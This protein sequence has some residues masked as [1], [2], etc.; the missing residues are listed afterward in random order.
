MCGF[1]AIIGAGFA[2]AFFSK[3]RK[4]NRNKRLYSETGDSYNNGSTYQPDPFAQNA[5]P[6]PALAASA[7][8]AADNI[9]GHNNQWDHQQNYNYG[10]IAP[11]TPMTSVAKQH[12]PYYST[13]PTQMGYAN[14][15]NMN[16]YY[17]N[18]YQQQYY[19]PNAAYYEQQHYDQNYVDSQKQ[20]YDA[21]AAPQHQSP[22]LNHNATNLAPNHAPTTA[23]SNVYSSPHSYPD[24][25]VQQAA[26]GNNPSYR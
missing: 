10:N 18:N 20:Q 22:V 5:R 15:P 26:N 19:D 2:Y 17:N 8:V 3:T 23:A 13:G 1:I 24:E 12:D 6:S 21:Y 16:G 11:Q 9:H 25:S 14:D 7:A 4:N